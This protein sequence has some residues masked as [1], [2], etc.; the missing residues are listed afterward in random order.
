[1]FR[2]RPVDDDIVVA[3]K[4]ACVVY[5]YNASHYYALPTRFVMCRQWSLGEATINRN[6]VYRNDVRKDV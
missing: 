6:S 2:S 1:M 4:N 5:S 3:K